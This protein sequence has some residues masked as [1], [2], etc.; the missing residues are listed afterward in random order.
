MRL[1]I[2]KQPFEAEDKRELRDRARAGCPWAAAAVGP[3]LAI[4]QIIVPS[5]GKAPACFSAASGKIKARK[6]ASRKSC[7]RLPVCYR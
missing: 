1:N 3:Q 7:T 4:A 6:E 5:C 2:N